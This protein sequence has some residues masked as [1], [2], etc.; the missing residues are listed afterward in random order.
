MSQYLQ[1]LLY[2]LL[3]QVRRFIEALALNSAGVLG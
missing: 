1:R 3:D 2:P